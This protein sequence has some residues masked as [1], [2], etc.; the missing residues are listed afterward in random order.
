MRSFAANIKTL[1]LDF[2]NYYNESH[3]NFNISKI[4]K[5]NNIEKLLKKLV[6]IKDER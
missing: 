1:I 6:T 3:I 4:P 5:L 2:D